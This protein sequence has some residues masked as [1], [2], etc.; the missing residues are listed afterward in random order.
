MGKKGNRLIGGSVGSILSG[1]WGVYSLF[2]AAKDLPANADWLA[3][4]LA[5]PPVYA[6]WLLFGVCVIFLAWVFWSRDDSSE[7]SESFVID[8][9]ATGTSSHAIVNNGTMHIGT[10]LPPTPDSDTS[11]EQFI[12]TTPLPMTLP[13]IA[14]NDLLKRIQQTH[15]ILDDGSLEALEKIREIGREIADQMSLRK[16]ATWGRVNGGTLEPL[17]FEVSRKGFGTGRNTIGE[18]YHMLQYREVDDMVVNVTDLRFLR[19]EIDGVWPYD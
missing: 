4:M 7:K 5:D 8:Q 10:S 12:S 16:L 18:I 9:S 15:Q 3:K 14:L 17:P 1:I 2:T 11:L 19:A 13:D 6:P